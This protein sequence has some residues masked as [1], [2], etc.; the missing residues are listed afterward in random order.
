MLLAPTRVAVLLRLLRSWDILRGKAKAKARVR[1][2]SALVISIALKRL[3][4]GGSLLQG[5][6]MDVTHEEIGTSTQE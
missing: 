1:L 6:A 2:D 3:S 5:N 4:V